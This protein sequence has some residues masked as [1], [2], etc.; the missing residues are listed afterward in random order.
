MKLWGRRSVGVD[1]VW[2]YAAVD[3]ARKK[4]FAHLAAAK[5]QVMA[6]AGVHGVPL[7]RVEFVVPFVQTISIPTCGCT[8]RVTPLPVSLGEALGVGFI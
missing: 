1:G 6:W 2:Q 3:A 5:A 7:V 4:Q 8:T